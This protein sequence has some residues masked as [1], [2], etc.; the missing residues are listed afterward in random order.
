MAGAKAEV[1]DTIIIGGGPGGLTAAL[2]AARYKLKT[3]VIAKEIGGVT[4][5]ASVVE[6]WPGV[7]KITGFELMKSMEKHVKSYNVPVLGGEVKKILK[8]KPFEVNALIGGKEK[9]FSA[10]T[11]ILALGLKRRRLSVE[12]EDKFM[13]KGV[14]YCATCDAPVFKGKV[15]GVIGGSDSA[16]QSALLL[17]EYAKKVYIIYRK[18][19]LRAEPIYIEK[20]KK[21]PKI[22]LVYNANVTRILGSKMVEGVELDTGKKLDLNGLF[23][24]IGFTPALS[25]AND[26]GVKTTDN[27]HIIIDDDAATNVEGVYA[28]GDIT[29]K[30]LRQIVTAS[31]FGATAAY[32]I[33]RHLKKAKAGW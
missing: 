32:S 10:R 17:A 21:S 26:L 6:N 22:E 3:L 29:D 24:E 27:G 14:S 7:E 11:L 9:S 4:N 28:A 30:P 2:Y 20:I 18:G 8:K 23:I 13:G 19:K 15:T 33:F 12:G 16:A 25:L 31:G 5:E 1:Y